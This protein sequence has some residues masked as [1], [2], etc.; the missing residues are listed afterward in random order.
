MG[1][2]GQAPSNIAHGDNAGKEA[3]KAEPEVMHAV[4]R[5]EEEVRMWREGMDALA[6]KL[7]PALS[8]DSA[9]GDPGASTYG[10]SAPLAN[11][12]DEITKMVEVGSQITG[13]LICRLE[14]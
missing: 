9:E 3:V 1:D 12:L 8:Q 2:I 5:L 11:R 14:L 10:Y 13:D 6:E 7:E 4:R